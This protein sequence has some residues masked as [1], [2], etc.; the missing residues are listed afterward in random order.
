MPAPLPAPLG[1][2]PVLSPLVSI[3]RSLTW[4]PKLDLH[5]FCILILLGLRFSREQIDRKV[6]GGTV[7]LIES[8]WG[9]WGETSIGRRVGVRASAVAQSRGG[10]WLL[11]PD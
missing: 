1:R 8:A 4:V 7:V 6:C 10:N 3:A 9:E 5:D 2:R 11:V